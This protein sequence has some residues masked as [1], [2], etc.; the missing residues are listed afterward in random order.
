MSRIT[1]VEN[2]IVSVRTDNGEEKRFQKSE[3]SFEPAVGESVEILHFDGKDILQRCVDPHR[4]YTPPIKNP[5]NKKSVNKVAY[6]LL[7]FLLGSFGAHKFYAKKIG[8]GI[9]Y[10]L[11]SWTGIPSVVAFIETIIG[12]CKKADSDGNI[13]I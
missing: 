5:L 9:I 11:F 7:A 1:S 2:G 12:L 10:L 13:L 3:L 4:S 8:L 6:C